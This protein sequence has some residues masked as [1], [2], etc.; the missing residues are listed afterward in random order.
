MAASTEPPDNGSPVPPAAGESPTVDPVAFT[1]KVEQDSWQQAE[2]HATAAGFWGNFQWVAGG[3]AAVLAAAAS[4]SAFSN[5]PTVAGL[6]ALGASASAALVT[7]LRPGD[8]SGQHLR[9]AAAY[10]A[11]QATAR[12][13]WQFGLEDHSSD[14]QKQLRALTATWVDVT[15]ASPRVPR[16]LVKKTKSFTA[17]SLNYYP[18]P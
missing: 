11:L 9:S 7:A 10:N 15:A 2:R 8:I 17:G 1:R 3:L 6:L 13:L 16:R 12:D 18:S 5:N 4:A 14:H